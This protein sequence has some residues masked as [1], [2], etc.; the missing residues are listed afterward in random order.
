MRRIICVILIS[1]FVLASASFSFADGFTNAQASNITQELTSN[2]TSYIKGILAGILKAI[3]GSSTYSGSDNLFAK[4][5]TIANGLT[6]QNATGIFQSFKE[7]FTGSYNGSST[8]P[9]RS[10]VLGRLAAIDKALFGSHNLEGSDYQGIGYYTYLISESLK[11]GIIDFSISDGTFIPNIA[12]HSNK[13]PLRDGEIFQPSSNM[14]PLILQNGSSNSTA[15]RLYFSGV[16][17][18]PETFGDWINLLNSNVIQ[19][20][21]RSWGQGTDYHTYKFNPET[22]ALDSYTGIALAD[23]LDVSL[24]D[25]VNSVGRLSYFMVDEDELQAKKD[26]KDVI[27]GAVQGFLSPGESASLSGSNVLEFKVSFDSIKNGFG[28]SA[29]AADSFSVL[30]SGSETYSWFSQSTADD[31]DSVGSGSMLRVL[32]SDTPA[33]DQY[34]QD[35]LSGIH[36]FD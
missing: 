24:G 19:M 11:N 20:T 9:S 3:S 21:F 18:M 14:M 26:N 4:L 28:S 30:S 33:L 22:F 25:L 23:F 36:F 16:Q 8:Y 10:S 17:T 34:Y 1:A 15:H 27:V 12:F 13:D 29:S 31:L 5:Q 6:S 7:Y 32:G 2:S 35:V